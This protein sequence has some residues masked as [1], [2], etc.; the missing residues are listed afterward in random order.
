METIQEFKTFK[1]LIKA[2]KTVDMLDNLSG[3]GPFTLLAPTDKAFACLYADIIGVLFRDR[4]K[5]IDVLNFHIIPEYITIKEAFDR[6]EMKTLSG[7]TINFT[8]KG[9][10]ANVD[11]AVVCEQDIVC[12]NGIIHIIDSVLIP[13]NCRIK[14]KNK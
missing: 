4:I 13:K 10:T 14:V 7:M 8:Q 3:D 6:T 9:K 12:S 2:I 5:L 11:N 1:T